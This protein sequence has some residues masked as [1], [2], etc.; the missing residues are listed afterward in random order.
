MFLKKHTVAVMFLL[1]ISCAPLL[2]PGTANAIPAFSRQ[3]KTECSTCHTI[4]PELNE[5]GDAFLKNGYVYPHKKE[6]AKAAAKA[7]EPGN[8]WSAISGLPQQIPLSLT[9]SADL[10]Y[11]EDAADGNKVDLSARSITL[12]AGGSFRDLFGF[13]ATY[14]LYSQG[15][16]RASSLSNPANN[17]NVPP[18]NDPDLDELFLVWRQALGSPVNMKVGRFEPKLS[19]WKK[20]NRILPVPSYASTTYRVGLSPFS[21]DAT[22]DGVELNA[23]LGNR[24]F[25]AGGVVDR[26]GQDREDGYGHISLKIG[27]TD[28]KGQEPEV[29]LEKDS[30]W[31]YLSVTLGSFGYWG[32]NGEFNANGV[33]QNLNSFRRI[34]AEADILYQRLHL[35]GSGSFGR[36]SNPEFAVVKS[37]INSKVYTLEGE[38]YLGAPVNLVPIFRYE[39]L[40]AGDGTIKRLTPAI[41]YTPLQNVRMSIEYTHSIA[42]EGTGNIAFASIA[43][44]M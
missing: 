22:E 27:G 16:Q 33:A 10:A 24:I 20:S 8:E 31:D 39:Y 12:Q 34:G 6:G 7:T 9:A 32:Q 2:A 15:M 28:L 5:F 17:T 26:N 30:L 38:Y 40:N 19:L 21:S 13:F 41:A 1:G 18:G 4:Y 35:K 36:D 25:V 42:P 11:D 3:H 14:N 37:V 43:F 23:L 29:D 44:S